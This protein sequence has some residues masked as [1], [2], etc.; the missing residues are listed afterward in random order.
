M[1]HKND[2]YWTDWETMSIHRADKNTGKAVT[3]IK[4]GLS[5][6]MDVRIFHRELKKKDNP[7][8]RNNGGCSHLCLLSHAS[9]KYSCACPT[10]LNLYVRNFFLL[11]EIAYHDPAIINL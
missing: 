3:T 4:S 6:L 8:G 2:I 9:K 10:G 1:V 7:C 11:F 5:G